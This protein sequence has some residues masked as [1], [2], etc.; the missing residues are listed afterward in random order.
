MAD[1]AS[2]E[3]IRILVV[4]TDRVGDVILSTPVIQALSEA[5]PNS[6]IALMVREG[7]APL[8]AGLPGVESVLIYDPL[9]KHRGASGFWRLV[10]ELRK[11]GFRISVS[12]QSDR[13][14]A[15]ALFFA[16]IKT[17]V[18]PLSKPHSYLFY[19]RGLRQ[20]RSHV[21]MHE[22]DY[23]LQ[24]L[25][26]L[27]IRVRTR[28]VPTQVAISAA[29]RA[30]ARAWLASA[31]AAG[32]M[33][34]G[35]RLIVI[36]PG[37]GG[38]ALNWPESHYLD[39][40]RALLRDGHRIVVTAGPTE[41]RLHDKFRESLLPEFEGRIAFY[42]GAGV[43]PIDRLAGVLAESALV[44]APSTGPLHL[45]VALGRPVVTFY[46]PIRVQSAIRW[47]PYHPDG[48]ASQVFVPEVYC[49]EDFECRG[50]KCNYFPCMRTI[51]VKEVHTK[52]TRA[53]DA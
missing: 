9:G 32:D 4:R 35:S 53:L 41:G 40:A 17:R 23:C 3:R 37:M 11:S 36:H 1:P 30:D 21:E 19:N 22:T 10:R 49:G 48:Q 34:G 50:S 28:S 39:L 38:S 42:G 27:G 20:R 51:A 45:A 44:V 47:G 2:I 8:V 26:R 16:R 14:V 24:L 12:L 46:P 29:A 18:G 33:A 52:A 6:R 13:R 43:G 15:A 25:R 5:Y 7:V 31:F